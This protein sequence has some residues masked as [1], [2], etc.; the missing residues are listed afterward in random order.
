MSASTPTSAW[1]TV[2]GTFAGISDPEA[3]V[4]ATLAR[5]DEVSLL[6]GKRP[7]FERDAAAIVV[8]P[9][10]HLRESAERGPGYLHA[11]LASNSLRRFI[12]D[13]KP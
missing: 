5:H 10:G 8:R 1:V 3:L 4:E 2:L 12:G 13:L 11:G 9:V 6:K 7:W